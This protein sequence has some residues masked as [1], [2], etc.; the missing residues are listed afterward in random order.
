[1]PLKGQVVFSRPVTLPNGM[2]TLAIFGRPRKNMPI[3]LLEFR[4]CE[5][6]PNG[7][8]HCPS[9]KTQPKQRKKLQ[10]KLHYNRIL[11]H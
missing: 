4:A 2:R 10:K 11:F 8:F 9:K 5:Q 1:M 3:K 7:K 6:L